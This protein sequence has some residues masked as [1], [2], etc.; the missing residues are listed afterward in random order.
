MNQYLKQILIMIF[1]LLIQCHLRAA[2]IYASPRIGYSR[3]KDRRERHCGG[4]A[5]CLKTEY[6][7]V[8]GVCNGFEPAQIP[9]WFSRIYATVW[10]SDQA[11]SRRWSSSWTGFVFLGPHTINPAAAAQNPATIQQN[12]FIR[13]PGPNPFAALSLRQMQVGVRAFDGTPD[14]ICG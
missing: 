7:E 12:P 9:Q 10:W 5:S 11:T 13:P 2:F 14:K 6:A 8:R 4:T 3:L 1:Y